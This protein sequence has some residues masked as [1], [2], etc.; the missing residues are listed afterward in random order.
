MFTTLMTTQSIY[1]GQISF[2]GNDKECS[3]DDIIYTSTLSPTPTWSCIDDTTIHKIISTV[4]SK[5]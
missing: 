5:K 3:S 1:V 2:Y 4:N